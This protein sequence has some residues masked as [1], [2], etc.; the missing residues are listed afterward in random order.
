[1]SGTPA[2]HTIDS[3]AR[4]TNPD[5]NRLGL[6]YRAEAARLG[7]PVVPI[8]D[9]H[10]HV[11]G[12]K[13]API[14]REVAARYGVRAVVTQTRFEDAPAVRDALGTMARFVAIPDYGSTDREH[15][16][17][18]GFLE[19][20][21]RWREDYDARIVK[22]WCAPRLRELATGPQAPTFVPLDSPWRV[23]IAERAQAL[24]MMIKVHVADPDTWFATKYA[25]ASKYGT[26]RS[27]YE[28]LERMADRFAGPWIIAH[29][30][31]WPEDLAFLSGLLDRHPNVNL[32]TS[33]TKWM[34]R[35]LSRH[36]RDEIVDFLTRYAGRILFGS[37]IVTTDEHLAPVKGT[38][39]YAGELASSPEQAFELYASRYWALR[40]MW[41]TD[42]NGPSPIADPDLALVEPEKHSPQDAPALVG[43]ALPAEMLRMLYAGAAER[44]FGGWITT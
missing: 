18:V 22:F 37:D 40:T 1:M 19:R 38:T 10:I 31:G 29:M 9:A 21:E 34:V 5:A 27:H 42:Y 35:E 44:L 6:D 14:F 13:A 11:N 23:R 3:P 24:G 41:E 26:K 43:R 8:V 20:I 28:P 30:G 2:M 36:T 4:Q 15:A 33:A 39:V 12:A 16:L 17:T 25:D 32:D 7:P